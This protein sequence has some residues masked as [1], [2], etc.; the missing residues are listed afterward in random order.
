MIKS[1]GIRR[2]PTLM[3]FDLVGAISE[4]L[5]ASPLNLN[6][7]VRGKAINFTFRL[8]L[9]DS[10][11]KSHPNECRVLFTAGGRYLREEILLCLQQSERYKWDQKKA[12]EFLK[13]VL[14]E[15]LG[16]NANRGLQGR[17]GYEDRPEDM[18]GTKLQSQNIL[19]QQWKTKPNQPD[20]YMAMWAARRAKHFE[21][22]IRQ[23]RSQ[24][25]SVNTNVKRKERQVLD[26]LKNMFPTVDLEE[27]LKPI[28][29]KSA[30]I[31]VSHASESELV[32]K[33]VEYEASVTEHDVGAK[34][35]RTGKAKN[36]GKPLIGAYIAL[37]NKLIDSLSRPA[38]IP[39]IRRKASR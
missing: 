37:G 3:N 9:P 27:A 16:K 4:F 8:A 11:R 15:A 29:W 19:L 21:N 14:K 20:P 28:K 23:A 39:N 33:F 36:S 24:F 31:E 2:S 6:V 32:E 1:D 35:Q 34:R 26:K 13:R 38:I 10:L 7:T 30:F 17:E 5:R 22:Q 18:V 12:H 25:R